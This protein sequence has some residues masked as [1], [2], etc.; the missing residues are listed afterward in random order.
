MILRGE[1]MMAAMKE[2]SIL[3]AGEL[4]HSI[5]MPYEMVMGKGPLAIF[6]AN[7][8]VISWPILKRS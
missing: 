2:H 5:G 8:S 6:R 7:S 4:V 1:S 3:S